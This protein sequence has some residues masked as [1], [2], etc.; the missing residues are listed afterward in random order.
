MGITASSPKSVPFLEIFFREI[1]TIKM[2]D[3]ILWHNIK[4]AEE[5]EEEDQEAVGGGREG[6]NSE[7]KDVQQSEVIRSTRSLREGHR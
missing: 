6:G 7:L 2:G 1:S 3:S 4:I 5:E